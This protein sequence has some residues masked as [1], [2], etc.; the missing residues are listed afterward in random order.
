MGITHVQVEHTFPMHTYVGQ[1][2]D[3]DPTDYLVSINGKNGV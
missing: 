3:M 1:M 2:S